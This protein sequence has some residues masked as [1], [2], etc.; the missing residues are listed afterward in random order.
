MRIPSSQPNPD[1]LQAICVTN[2]KRIKDKIA[3]LCGDD[4]KVAMQQFSDTCASAGYKV[5][6]LDRKLSHRRIL[7]AMFYVVNDTFTISGVS[8][9]T[10]V[11]NPT[12]TGSVDVTPTVSSSIISGSISSPSPSFRPSFRPSSSPSAY[13]S[14]IVSAGSS[15]RHVPAAAF[16]AVVF[17]GFAAAL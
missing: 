8:S 1:D 9:S 3:D 15:D 4:T 2:G 6:M 12:K 17:F 11:P 14:P 13:P 10:A 5:G 7:S 16:A